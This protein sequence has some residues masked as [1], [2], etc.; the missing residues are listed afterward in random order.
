[1]SSLERELDLLERVP[2]MVFDVDTE[3]GVQHVEYREGDDCYTLARSFVEEHCLD[4]ALI[5][6]LAQ[7]MEQKL[8]EG[9]IPPP[10]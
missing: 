1:M 9:Q 2:I 6:P 3:D 4:E 8:N 10:R 5:E 7:H